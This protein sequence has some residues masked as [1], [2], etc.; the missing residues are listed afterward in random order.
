MQARFYEAGDAD[1]WDALIGRA[2]MGTLQHTRRFLGYHGDRFAD[3]SLVISAEGELAAV[4]PAAVNP[5]DATCVVSHPGAAHGGLVFDERRAAAHAE[6]SLRAASSAFAQAGFSRLL[7]KSVPPHLHVKVSQADAY[8]LWR[9]GARLV[10]RDLWNVVDLDRGPD[11]RSRRRRVR[12][13]AA[14]GIDVVQD[15]RPAAY[16]EFF[17]VLAGRLGERHGTRPVHTPEE[18]LDL[19]DRLGEAVCLWLARGREGDCLAGT[20]LFDFRPAAFH[21]QYGCASAAGREH[22]ALD[23]VLTT[24]MDHAAGQRARYF[25]FGASTEH[26]G[27]V[28]NTGLYDYKASFG[29]GAV[30]HDFYE[31]DLGGHE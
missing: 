1:A 20:W 11:P 15:D 16:E 2:P 25:S 3:R 30:A 7:Y 29:S 9:A 17:E 28:L 5:D 4:L 12:K 22:H 19:K 24:V 27:R 13:A 14:Q 31:L 21:A 8:A 10:R 6:A 26:E 23:L 18:M